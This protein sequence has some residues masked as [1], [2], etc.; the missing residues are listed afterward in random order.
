MP[1]AVCALS[2]GHRLSPAAFSL[3][4]QVA[5]AARWASAHCRP[6]PTVDTRLKM[7][8]GRRAT[9]RPR[10][11]RSGL[12]GVVAASSAWTGRWHAVHVVLNAIAVGRLTLPPSN[13]PIQPTVAPL[14]SALPHRFRTLAAPGAPAKVTAH[15]TA[16]SRFS[17]TRGGAAPG[18]AL[19]EDR[20]GWPTPPPQPACW[21]HVQPTAP[22]HRT[23]FTAP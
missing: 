15:F 14:S 16:L 7:H 23:P 8:E 21:P 2:P 5:S 12:A 13:H 10:R 20:R 22:P 19:R 11:L 17:P 6:S 3:P 4:R 18:G 9:E 1:H